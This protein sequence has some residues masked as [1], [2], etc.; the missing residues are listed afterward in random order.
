MPLTPPFISPYLTVSPYIPRAS[1]KAAA[2]CPP[3]P[4]VSP[5]ISLCIPTSLAHSRETRRVALHISLHLPILPHILY[6]S[7]RGAAG[8]SYHHYHSHLPISSLIPQNPPASPAH[9]RETWHAASCIS[10]CLPIS[11]HVSLYL[12]ILPHT[13]YA[14]AGDRTRCSPHPPISL[15]TSPYPLLTH[16]KHGVLLPTSLRVLPH[17]PTPPAFL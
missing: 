10:P 8:C 6:I 3:Y 14:P 11:P 16:E 13:F 5:H 4:P 1:A 15:H 7:A 9:L 2:C 12:P 17:L